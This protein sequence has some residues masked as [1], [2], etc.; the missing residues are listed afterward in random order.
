MKPLSYMTF[1][2]AHAHR[3]LSSTL[4]FA[5]FVAGMS[6]GS[7]ALADPKPRGS[8]AAD[9]QTVANMYVGK[10][11]EWKRCRGGVYFGGGG[12][13]E[14]YCH[15]EG[16]DP[17]V[18]IGKWSVTRKGKVCS[19][20]QWHWGE[21]ESNSKQNDKPDCIQHVVDT[22]GQIWRRFGDDKD[23]WRFGP[24]SVGKGNTLKR[25]TNKLKRKFKL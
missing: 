3:A 9:G 14:G 25:Q 19:D 4:T 21:G 15:L 22:E 5:V 17:S 6:A 11:Q 18:G 20:M 1:K 16:K 13:A 8:K 12:K 10:T 7:I 24:D 23:W 2:V